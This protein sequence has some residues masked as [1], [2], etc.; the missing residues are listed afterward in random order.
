MPAAG[1]KRTVPSPAVLAWYNAVPSVLWSV[2]SLGPLTVFCY[3]HVARPWLWGF[4]VASLLVYAVP[5]TWLRRLQLSAQPAV[6]RKLGVP[7]VGHLAQYGALVNRLLRRRY[8]HYRRLPSRA[9]VASVV[10][11]TYHYERFHWS[12]LLFFLLVSGYA[13]GQRAVGW[14]V[15]LM[16]LNIGYNLYPIWLQQYLRVRLQRPGPG[17]EG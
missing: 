16:L 2:L 7:V 6:Y 4:I 9:A 11:G 1:S 3:Q 17:A 15:V 10:R 12:M 14:A 8:P 13:I 5:A